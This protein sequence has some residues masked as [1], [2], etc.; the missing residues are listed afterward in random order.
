MEEGKHMLAT[1]ANRA[2]PDAPATP[3]PLPLWQALLLFGIPAV[4]F[5]LA[6]Y[7]GTGFLVAHGVAE[8]V[9]VITAFLVPS[10]LLLLAAV[11]A[12]P[13]SGYALSGAVM[14]TR[15]RLRRPRWRGWLW[16]LGGALFALVGEQILAFTGAL[17]VRIP[18]FTPPGY[19]SFLNPTVRQSLSAFLGVSLRGNWA[20]LAIFA[21]VVVV[22]VAAEELWWR[23][24]ILPRQEPV[25][26]KRTWLV[27][28]VL[29]AG[30][31]FVFYPWNVVVDLFFCCTVAFIAQR[32]KNTTVTLILHLLYNGL[33]PILLLLV[34]LGTVR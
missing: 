8:A 22:Q 25:Y 5:R 34:V 2:H 17:L 11:V 15:F 6:L 19:L 23:G 10:A 29:W 3:K 16:A 12:L 7:N 20:F 21:G 24:Y 32:T 13:L 28:G 1:V 4:V 31:H 9:A 27:H 18:A 14:R 26:D 30:F 33:T